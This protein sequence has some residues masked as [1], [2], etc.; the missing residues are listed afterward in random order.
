MRM[1]ASVSKI[2]DK[3]RSPTNINQGDKNLTQISFIFFLTYVFYSME[4]KASAPKCGSNP[5]SYQVFHMAANTMSHSIYNV[6]F[7]F[8]FC[9]SFFFFGHISSSIPPIPKKWLRLE[10]TSTLLNPKHLAYSFGIYPTLL[11]N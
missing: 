1:R 6:N 10:T 5:K 8:L 2:H 4:T 11:F 3:L 7:L 9:C